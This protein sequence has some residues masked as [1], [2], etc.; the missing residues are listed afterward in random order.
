[1]IF[2]H[3]ENIITKAWSIR[4][5]NLNERFIAFVRNDPLRLLIKMNMDTSVS[6]IFYIDVYV[7]GK[8]NEDKIL[9]KVEFNHAQSKILDH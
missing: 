1:M 2:K 7:K 3:L 6:Q 4:E 8:Y 9:E 5:F